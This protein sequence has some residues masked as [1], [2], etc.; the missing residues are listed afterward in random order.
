MERVTPVF[1]KSRALFWWRVWP[2]RRSGTHFP[3]SQSSWE[4]SGFYGDSARH[5][6]PPVPEW[7]A[8]NRSNGSRRRKKK[9]C[10][11]T[12]GSIMMTMMDTGFQW[13]SDGF[14][15][16]TNRRRCEPP[17]KRLRIDES[18]QWTGGVLFRYRGCFRS[19]SILPGGIPMRTAK[20][21]KS[22]RKI[23]IEEKWDTKETKMRLRKSDKFPV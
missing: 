16:V 12:M 13:M 11:I 23:N 18:K 17:R 15:A 7:H 3:P 10:L 14:R 9:Y 19:A 4:R 1:G 22:R 21:M 6:R 5:G 20:Y 2:L 8:T